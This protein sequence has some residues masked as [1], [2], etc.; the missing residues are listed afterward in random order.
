MA[1]ADQTMKIWLLRSSGAKAITN[2]AARR[3][4][5]LAAV[6][7]G[8]DL[9]HVRPATGPVSAPERLPAISVRPTLFYNNPAPL[10]RVNP[11]RPVA[12][13]Q[14]NSCCTAL[15]PPPFR[16]H[17]RRGSVTGHANCVFAQRARSSAL[18]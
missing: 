7:F 17:R 16:P 18:L 3:P 11:R 1:I 9:V 13:P 5:N 15:L 8:P 6:Y 12:F 14:R 2:V 10:Y 4:G